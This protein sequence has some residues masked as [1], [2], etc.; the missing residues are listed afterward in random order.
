LPAIYIDARL[1]KAAPGM[2]GNKTDANDADGLAHL[3]E[4]GFFREVRVKGYHSM[5]V[6]TL[7][8]APDGG[9]RDRGDHRGRLRG[10]DQGSCE[11]QIVALRRRLVRI[12]DGALS[13]EEADH[14][15]HISRR[16]GAPMRGL[17]Y[18]A[19]IV[20]LSRSRVDSDLRAWGLKLRERLGFKRAAVAVAPMLVVIM[21]AML[22]SGQSYRAKAATA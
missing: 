9:P 2:V 20:L 1:A 19:A 7:F 3:A 15:G 13:V 6:R 4:V 14:G 17:L 10:R 18:E 12:D 5:L 8:A 11:L 22:K 21:H 16:G